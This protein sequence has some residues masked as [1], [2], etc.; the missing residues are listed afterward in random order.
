MATDTLIANEAQEAAWELY[1]LLRDSDHTAVPGIKAL[2]P[3][4]LKAA[5]MGLCSE[6]HDETD[7]ADLRRYD[8]LCRED[9]GEPVK[10][11]GSRFDPDGGRDD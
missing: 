2:L 7:L 3:L 6:C 5:G 4:A 1:E 9:C 11:R 10:A 8:G